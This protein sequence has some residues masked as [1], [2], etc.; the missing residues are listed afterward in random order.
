MVKRIMNV[1]VVAALIFQGTLVSLV[2]SKDQ[3]SVR[4][5]L[6][7]DGN[8]KKSKKKSSGFRFWRGSG[9]KIKKK[10]KGIKKS[11][12]K[13]V[14]QQQDIYQ[15]FKTYAEVI[16]MVE[17]RAFR[18][19]DFS[20]FIQE[21][22]KS[23]VGQLDAHSAF[24]NCDSYKS[25]IESASGEFSGIGVSIISKNPED[26]SLAILE[27][28]R[29]GPAEKAGLKSGDKIVEV[30]GEKLRGMS[31][32][33]VVNKLKGKSGSTLKLKVLRDKK[34]KEFTVTRDIIK[35]QS[36]MC[37][38]FKKQGIYYLSLKIFAENAAAQV[39]DLLVKV[40]KGGCKGL[41]L[42][43]RR[44]P[45]GTLDSAIE[46]ASLFLDPNSLVT[47][48]KDNQKKVV[49]E[50]HTKS[51]PVLKSDKPIFI[52]VDNF[53]ASAAEILAGALQYYSKQEPQ[54]K[55]HNNN[56]N[57]MVFLVGTSTFGKGSVQEVIPVSNGCALK[58][59]TML[60]YLPG[61]ISI[62]SVGIKPDFTIKPK[63]VPVDEI[64]WI[65]EMFGQESSLTNHITVDEVKGK[66]R[67]TVEPGKKG[68]KSDSKKTKKG[69]N[70]EEP[71]KSW[72]ERQ[73][74]ELALDV[75]VQA[76]VNMINLLDLAKKCAPDRVSSRDK[77][78]T[79]LQE[80]YIT[81]DAAEIEKVE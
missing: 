65:S 77:A 31:A 48:T 43:L 27:V 33:E 20:S 72:D 5:F 49:S 4:S 58:L 70:E 75:Q 73:K 80:Q 54:S 17:R 1:V 25:A 71:E 38:L 79:F 44:N 53:T 76:S 47:V 13:L 28:I 66:K 46:M 57:L 6:L 60:Y 50:Y 67:K 61:D 11:N 2:A 69:K 59:T 23:A 29:G 39:S 52:L 9:G 45:G 14:D 19:V 21:S 24:F 74:E 42:D 51:D 68:K 8:E 3:R 30:E 55:E 56:N 7:A 78:Y 35:D 41:I 15:W 26:D 32:D 34:P 36:S 37:F 81:D 18:S 16:G 12:K 22:L 62:Q 40:N 63:M 10:R 64:K